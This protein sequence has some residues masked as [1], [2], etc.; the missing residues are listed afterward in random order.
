MP[1]REFPAPPDV[2]VDNPAG[3]LYL[4]DNE[5]TDNSKRITIG[6]D[7]QIQFQKRTATVWNLT[8]LE[9]SGGSLL[10]GQDT[11]IA[12][13]GHHLL[14]ESTAEGTK[15]LIV[16]SHFDDTG[17]QAA[18]AVILGAK[19]IRTVMQS[20]ATN[21]QDS[22]AH[23]GLANSTVTGIAQKAYFKVGATAA[24]AEVELEFTAGV[25]PADVTFFRKAFAA[26]VFPASTEIEIDL[27][28]G[29]EFS[30][31][32]QINARMT[33]ASAFGLLYNAAGTAFWFAL[34]IQTETT[35]DILTDAGF[36]LGDN[37]AATFGDNSE[38]TITHTGNGAFITNSAGNLDFDNTAAV[39]GYIFRLGADNE[40]TN[41]EIRNN[42]NTVIF[43]LNTDGTD[44]I[45]ENVTGDI[46]IEPAADLVVTTD[47]GGDFLFAS[48][49][50][51]AGST[52]GEYVSIGHSA[53]VGF[54]DS[55]GTGALE[56]R[57][58]G[59]AVLTL[60]DTGKLSIP[61]D[62]VSPQFTIGAN[63][64]FQFFHNGVTSHI[65]NFVGDLKITV[66]TADLVVETTINGHFLFTENEFRAGVSTLE[67]LRIGHDG[68]NAVIDAVGDG[69]L[70]FKHEGVS[71]AS[72]SDASI[73]NFTAATTIST[74]AGN[75]TVT[76]GNGGDF[77]FA[78][79]GFRAGNTTTDFVSIGNNGVKSFLNS[80][81]G[82]D[83]VVTV[84]GAERSTF[85]STDFRA[86]ISTSE[87]VRIGHDGTN[88]F[89]DRVG[90]GSLFFQLGGVTALVLDSAGGFTS[91]KITTDHT[92]SFHDG[93]TQPVAALPDLSRG[94][95]RSLLFK[96]AFDVSTQG[97]NPEA[98]FFRTDGI[99]M[100]VI[101]G[102]SDTVHEYDLSV[103]WDVSSAVALQSFSVATQDNDPRGLFFKPDGLV[104]YI[105]G[106]QNDNV[107]QYDLGT[108]WNVTTAVFDNSFSV[109]T[110]SANPASVV[111][112]PDGLSFYTTRF[113]APSRVAEYTMT[114]PWNVTT[115]SFSQGFQPS[116]PSNLI[117]AGFRADG[118]LLYVMSAGDD[119]IYEYL[120]STPWDM[121]T[122]EFQTS[123][124]V[125]QHGSTILRGFFMSPYHH[126]FYFAEHGA[127]DE[128]FEYD[129]GVFVDG[130]VVS[131]PSDVIDLVDSDD[132]DNLSATGTITFA[133]D[134]T[135]H[136]RGAITTSKV[137][138]VNTGITLHIEGDNNSTSNI[139]YTGAD[140]TTFF[141]GL[142]AVRIFSLKVI[143]STNNATLFNMTGGG[144]VNIRD[145]LNIKGWQLG[146]ASAQFFGIDS[147]FVD[148][149]SGFTLNNPTLVNVTD[150]AVEGAVLGSHFVKINTND[151][152]S[153]INFTDISGLALSASGSLFHLDTRINN[154]AIISIRNCKVASDINGDPV[155]DLFEQ[156]VSGTG[157]INS[158][159]DGTIANGSIT[160][161]ADNGSGG[162]THSSTTTYFE[163]EEVTITGT[164]SY[165]GTFQI[166]NVVAGVSFD[167]ITTF[168]AN[169]ATGT[170]ATVRLAITLAGGHPITT[171]DSI[172]I[173]GANFYN[174]FYTALNV[175][176]N[177]LTVNGTFIA[178]D[179]GTVDDDVGLDQSDPRVTG[180]SNGK[181]VDSHYIA[182]AHVNNNGTGTGTIVN[183]TFKD[184][185][186]G[187]AG[188]ALLASTTMERWRL[189]DELNGTFEYIGH[190]PFDGQITFDFT[191]VSSGGTQDFRFKWQH[192][193]GAGFVDLPDAVEALV[194]AANNSRSVTKTFPLFA[195]KGDKIKPQVTRNAGTSTL[196]TTYATIYAAQ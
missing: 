184:M 51:R 117:G 114:A 176:T 155:G 164:T 68:L 178:T 137:I 88:G 42:S 66:V 48:D 9:L 118:V 151:P 172:K 59:S 25:P 180:F 89:I 111:F 101:I 123:F 81:G 69:L 85:G 56:F 79:D 156:N 64:D 194:A 39:G 163:D 1:L 61:Q 100:Y 36:N 5:T 83:L 17:T 113:I 31:A 98:V 188:S 23:L 57:H 106:R 144:T 196:T 146:T 141:S 6:S 133:V 29:V 74:T 130:K 147:V 132:F 190:E 139:T 33:T 166:F 138:S 145:T 189:V 170:V 174:G 78:T 168:V 52:I 58:D 120:L 143:E 96:Q 49:H 128:I 95:I 191:L 72:L 37:I 63:D 129:L 13:A 186:F 192:D 142:G 177:L 77:L 43:R 55:V 181:F 161:Q 175:A 103:P 183:N 19:A 16:G 122:Q 160:A 150:W 179:T 102:A 148:V 107:Y 116:E 65:Q 7:D 162:T 20:D 40:N 45:I 60:S 92:Y 154:N 87:Y 12:A 112:K 24:T 158:V 94:R 99:K 187:T 115:A 4:E 108:A 136:I 21:D 82:D 76:T 105:A 159:A 167:T 104:M 121:S 50:L 67:Y 110:D 35:E 11:S 182:C 46:A 165:N 125:N 47:N 193:V 80:V 27:S 152:A 32:L 93:S 169:D 131:G 90:D 127:T 91:D 71:I 124:G 75:I 97:I 34:D 119:T 54:I 10:L 149:V 18:H 53:T 135:L 30:T 3:V 28:P 2:T 14:T 185:V 84:N 38:L 22:A 86:G 70:E 41:F 173:T 8:E 171:Q 44:S 140:S 109:V 157:T 134:T 153:I 62:L 73:L 26:S 15:A 195:E 126:K